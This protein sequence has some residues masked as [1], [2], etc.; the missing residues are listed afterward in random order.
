V[1]AVAGWAPKSGGHNNANISLG[2]GRETV[3][4]AKKRPRRD[5]SYKA[6]KRKYQETKRGDVTKGKKTEDKET[7]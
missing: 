1:N 6:R 3:R 5:L 4:T 2:K 7:V